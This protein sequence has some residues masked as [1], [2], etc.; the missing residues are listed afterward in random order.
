[1]FVQTANYLCDVFIIV[2]HVYITRYAVLLC[3][4]EPRHP[5][6][7]PLNWSHV[8]AGDCSTFDCN[9][10]REIAVVQVSPPSA[11]KTTTTTFIL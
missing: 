2:V 6:Q 11:I 10:V 4:F 7:N 3:F 8:A 9:V 5:S 1:M